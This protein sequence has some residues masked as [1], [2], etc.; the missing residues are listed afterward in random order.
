MEQTEKKDVADV[1]KKSNVKVSL[2]SIAYGIFGCIAFVSLVVIGV[3]TGLYLK[4]KLTKT[5]HDAAMKEL[6][7]A[8]SVTYKRPEFQRMRAQRVADEIEKLPK[9]IHQ[10]LKDFQKWKE[11]YKALFKKTK[12]SSSASW[13]LYG[14]S[15]YYF[16]KGEKT[17][18]DAENF[19]ASRDAH[20]ASVLNNE[21]QD[22]I[23][24]QLKQASWIGLADENKKGVWAWTDGSRF[25]K[26]FWSA[27][28]PNKTQHVSQSESSCTFITPSSTDRNWNDDDCHKLH[29][30]VCK[31]YL[32]PGQP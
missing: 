3:M 20:L 15:L 14:K 1:K 18:P 31:N 22:F 8:L 30:W 11:D 24:S 32:G 5:P 16:S 26:Q 25:Q 21:E 4:V 28:K 17:W 2:Y 12:R 6:R 19:C 23:T 7:Y 29:G 13:V 9:E 10:A 27:G